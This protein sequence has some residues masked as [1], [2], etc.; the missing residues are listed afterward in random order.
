MLMLI[1]PAVASAYTRGFDVTNASGLTVRLDSISGFKYGIA[2]PPTG[3]YVLIGNRQHVEVTFEFSDSNSGTL[4]Y[5]LYRSDNTF[6]GVFSAELTV[7]GIDGDSVS[8]C[9]VHEGTQFGYQ[10]AASG[11]DIT[12]LDPPG[13]SYNVPAAQRQAQADLLNQLCTDQ[14]V[15]TCSFAVKR[16]DKVESPPHPVGG[17]VV[18][19]TDVDQETRLTIEDK[20]GQSNSVDVSV[21]AGFKLFEVVDA[22]IQASYKHTWTQEHTF[23]QD[24]KVTVEPHKGCAITA[25]A[26]MLRDTGDFTLKLGNSTWTLPDVY[27][28][29]PDPNPAK[30]GYHID[31][32]K[33]TPEEQATLPGRLTVTPIV[34]G[35]YTAPRD[36]SIAQPRLQL[37]ISGPAA[38]YPGELAEYRILLAGTGP[39]ARIVYRPGA[40]RVRVRIAAKQFGHWTVSSLGVGVSHTLSLRF[41]VPSRA[42]ATVCLTATATARHAISAQTRA[43][44]VVDPAPTSGLG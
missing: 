34:R 12:L 37:K 21:K 39:A 7:V 32:T 4:T 8:S 6:V 13:T 26:P 40:V 1:S 11:S 22:S 25:T 41:M 2:A 44:T 17:Y 24:I 38:L 27:F 30:Y 23:S 9:S 10:C 33:L 5:S 36:P 43:C 3:T 28:D 19:S 15:G 16:E 35:V 29:T 18:N 20:I 31:C 42:S 14:G